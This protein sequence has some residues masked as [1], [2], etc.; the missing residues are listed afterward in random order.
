VNDVRSASASSFCAVFPSAI[1]L[2]DFSAKVAKN[3]WEIR[4]KIGLIAQRFSGSKVPVKQDIL[5]AKMTVWAGST[6]WANRLN[7]WLANFCVNDAVK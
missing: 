6:L 1:I 5:H 2:R 4:K 3:L 7:A